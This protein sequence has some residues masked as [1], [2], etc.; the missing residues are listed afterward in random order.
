MRWYAGYRNIS[1]NDPLE[2]TVET[3]SEWIVDKTQFKGALPNIPGMELTDNL[4]AFV[5]RKL[6]TLNTGHAITAYLGK[7]AG[8]HPLARLWRALP[9]AV[10]LSP[11]TYMMAVSTTGQWL[12]LGWP[13]RVPEAD[14]VPPP[15]PPAYRV[16]TGVEDPVFLEVAQLSQN[17][18]LRYAEM[19]RKR[20]LIFALLSV[21]LEDEHFIPLLLRA[22]FSLT[23]LDSST[24]RWR[25][26]L[27]STHGRY[28]Y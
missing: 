12:I 6:F 16:L 22:I 18:N 8:H 2:V 7:L 13:E 1:S 21:F 11:H 26:G 15:A 28:Y 20:A 10:R 9:E 17:K 19:L 23:D 24:A 4:M 3:F 27:V 25:F 5:E 14:E